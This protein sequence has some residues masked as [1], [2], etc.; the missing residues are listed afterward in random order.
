MLGTW[1]W[2]T[3]ST[4]RS[5]LRC[6]GLGS[7]K[8]H[9]ARQVKCSA[10][11]AAKQR[12]DGT[13]V[14]I[15]RSE[16]HSCSS[17]GKKRHV[18]RREMKRKISML[19][20]VAVA[21]DFSNSSR[22][23][24]SESESSTD[25]G[26][27]TETISE[28]EE[29]EDK[30]DDRFSAITHTGRRPLKR[31]HDGPLPSTAS[32]VAKRARP[33]DPSEASRAYDLLASVSKPLPNKKLLRKGINE[34]KVVRPDFP[35]LLLPLLNPYTPQSGDVSLPSPDDV[36]STAADFFTRIFAF[37][38]QQGFAT[39]RNTRGGRTRFMCDERIDGLHCKWALVARIDE[40]GWKVKEIEHDHICD[41]TG[42]GALSSSPTTSPPYQS[43]AE[44]STSSSA[45]FPLQSPPS[46]SKPL[47][48]P[49]T[50]SDTAMGP[51]P[52]PRID[53]SHPLS[54][55]DLLALFLTTTSPSTAATSAC[56]LF[57]AGAT[58]FELLIDLL[59]F[60]DGTD[61]A[62]GEL[63]VEQG[64]ASKEE[65]TAVLGVLRKMKEEM[66]V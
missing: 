27:E 19:E 5:E 35:I 47:F 21:K 43:L 32:L 10:Y 57:A 11:I 61:E 49:P 23:T 13:L 1:R 16:W 26:E 56:L 17:N 59:S 18:A 22:T 31:Q 4:P 14:V 63:L 48:T 38:E 33:S 55:K 42:S 54:E 53:R 15:E 25:S 30:Q 3:Q 12:S 24:Y 2:V 65:K 28:Q 51:Q 8:Q 60:E 58:T 50:I 36:F 46:P 44:T 66:E 40:D 41:A 29:E 45:D 37:A 62:L 20:A 9:A 6:D 7:R 52:P 39:S 34:L 64:E